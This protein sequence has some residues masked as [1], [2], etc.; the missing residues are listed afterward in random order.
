[1]AEERKRSIALLLIGFFAIAVTLGVFLVRLRHAGPYV[2]PEGGAVIGA[3]GLIVIAGLLLW[4]GAPRAFNWIAIIVMPVALFPAVYSIVGEWE[5]VISIYAVDGEG[6]Q[7]NLRLWVVDR[8]DGTWVGMPRDKALKHELDGAQLQM[9][10]G[11]EFSCVSPALSADM[12]TTRQIHRMKV[13][14][15]RAAQLAGAI[16][17]YP[18][19]ASEATAVLRLDS[20]NGRRGECAMKVI[21]LAAAFPIWAAAASL[22]ACPHTTGKTS[23]V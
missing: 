3:C 22:P 15:Y 14:K 18:L 4:Q 12:E 6:T 10:R 9:L 16:G 7:T 17:L 2:M 21:P 13:E 19:G 5:E 8:E 1:M 11:G 20:C 23:L